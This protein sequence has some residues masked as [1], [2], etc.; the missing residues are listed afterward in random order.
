MLSPKSYI[1]TYPFILRS[2]LRHCS[3]NIDS[4]LCES[5]VPLRRPEL[6][7]LQDGLCEVIHDWLTNRKENEE[8][9]FRVPKTTN[10][11]SATVAW[12]YAWVKSTQIQSGKGSW[13]YLLP[14][15][16]GS[17][18]ELRLLPQEIFYSSTPSCT[19]K[20]MSHW[21]A[22]TGGDKKTYTIGTNCKSV[23]ALIRA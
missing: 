20:F 7:R 22:K 2:H 9:T 23:N 15:E 13:H 5:A 4:W 16:F 11:V 3:S 17:L 1:A 19:P 21:H 18:S 6:P 10:V 12:V 8:L 14:P